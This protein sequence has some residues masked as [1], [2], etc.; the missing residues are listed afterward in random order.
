VELG[1]CGQ[2]LVEGAETEV[3]D[4]LADVVSGAAAPGRFAGERTEVLDSV[5]SV[6]ACEKSSL[7]ILKEGKV[8]DADAQAGSGQHPRDPPRQSDP[9]STS[10]EPHHR[11]HSTQFGGGASPPS[12]VDE[13]GFVGALFFDV[14]LM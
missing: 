13:V 6:A 9:K 12:S 8:H 2:E 5:H 14:T 1:G 3:R 11:F 10:G 4:G 7:R